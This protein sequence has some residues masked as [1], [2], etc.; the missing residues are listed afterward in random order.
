MP[1]SPRF[2]PSAGP[3]RR[4]RAAKQFTDVPEWARGYVGAVV[5]AGIMKGYNETKF[6]ANDFITREQMAVTFV[7]AFGYED[8]AA[9]LNLSIKFADAA[10]VSDWAKADVALAAEIGFIQGDGTNFNPKG[11]AERQAVARLAYEF[12]KNKDVYV[13]KAEEVV[14][15]NLKVVSVTVINSKK[16]EVTFNDG[17]KQTVDLL[18]ALKPNVETEVKVTYKGKEFVVK[19]KWEADN[20]LQKLLVDSNTVTINDTNYVVAS[21]AALTVNGLYVAFGTD[22]LRVFQVG[23]PVQFTT[24]GAPT[25]VI[26]SMSATYPSVKGRVSEVGVNTNG[27]YVVVD[28]KTLQFANTWWFVDTSGN[29]NAGSSSSIAQGQTYTFITN[30]EGKVVTAFAHAANTAA[31]VV[32]AT[33]T[34]IEGKNYVVI[35]GKR[36]AFV[37]TPTIRLHGTTKSFADIGSVV[38]GGSKIIGNAILNAKGEVNTLDLYY[39]TLTGSFGTTSSATGDVGLDTNGTPGIDYY[40]KTGLNTFSTPTS[41]A[42]VVPSVTIILDGKQT[43]SDGTA[44]T[45]ADLNTYL[46]DSANT[47]ARVKLT[48][49]KSGQVIAIE[50]K[51][52]VVQGVV[53][54][55]RVVNNSEYY[56]TLNGKEYR[57]TGNAVTRFFA[58]DGN[59][60]PQASGGYHDEVASGQR[61]I[62]YAVLDFQG[63]IVDFVKAPNSGTAGTPQIANLV[64]AT[65]VATPTEKGVNSSGSETYAAA[66]TIRVMDQFGNIYEL[67]LASGTNVGAQII[68]NGETVSFSSI[69]KGDIVDVYYTGSTSPYDAEYVVIR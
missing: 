50:A 16:I 10:Q 5:K 42:T 32:T 12:Y 44:Y 27:Q 11:N 66:G 49:N 52:D 35:D 19:V 63:R 13:K 24:N 15:A 6:G 40:V 14:I 62:V 34:D 25:P 57:L 58:P 55:T 46:G 48:F 54:A 30:D 4:R 51:K 36:Y 56:V 47:N 37:T 26:I 33:G 60:V 43:K 1:N 59:G 22:A 65:V 9:G 21:N 38:S 68:K 53:T 41:A 39:E 61:V 3:E 7:R 31:G 20:V 17:S 28:G 69:K 45:L 23:K 29:V 67:T 2:W 64:G 18:E 8:E